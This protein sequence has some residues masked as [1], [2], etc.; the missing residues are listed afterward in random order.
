MLIAVNH[1]LVETRLNFDSLLEIGEFFVHNFEFFVRNFFENLP[2]ES[3]NRHQASCLAL[4]QTV[5]PLVTYSAR[6]VSRNILR[7]T[8]P[9]CL[10]S[11]PVMVA[12]QH[13]CC[14]MSDG[15]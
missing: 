1:D 6:L 15:G 8:W 10:M 11:T 5:H 14:L 3:P 4:V 12:L 9:E 13:V 7:N 2:Q